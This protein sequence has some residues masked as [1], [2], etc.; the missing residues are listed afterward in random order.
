MATQ[1]SK[2]KVVELKDLLKERGIPTTGLTR[3]QSIIDALE[4]RDSEVSGGAVAV[5]A[6]EDGKDG[7]VE[8]VAAEEKSDEGHGVRSD[9][10]ET[11]VEAQKVEADATEVKEAPALEPATED[12]GLDV[13]PDATS[14]PASTAT[15]QQPTVL[16]A[17]EPVSSKP[18]SELATPQQHSG[19]LEDASPESRKRK[20]R[21]PTP[22]LSDE[23]VSKK[24]KAAEEAAADPVKLTDDA[25]IEDA[26]VSV[27]GAGEM[28]TE[29]A[30][31]TVQ[32]YSTSDDLQDVNTED[33]TMTDQPA[34]PDAS[35]AQD[36]PAGAIHP[37]TRALYIR[38][39]I[40]PLQPA[41]LRD[42]LIALAGPDS[43]D[44]LIEHFHL[45]VLR[46]HAFAVFST[47]KAATRVRAALHGTVF[48]DEPARKSL[49]V[50]FVPEEKVAEWIEVEASAGTS[51]RDAR[52]WEVLYEGS[53]EGTAVQHVE[54]GGA[55]R[56]GSIRQGSMTQA[57]STGTGA[58]GGMPNAPLGP[59][60]NGTMIQRPS[61]PQPL[62]TSIAAE[63]QEA[64]TGDDESAVSVTANPATGPS[65]SSFTTLAKTFLC[66]TT[67]PHLYYLPKPDE[68]ATSRLQALERETSRDW[69]GARAG[70]GV[71]EGYGGGLRRYTFEDG[72]RLVDG[73]A[74]RG[75]FG[76]FG[77]DGYGRGAFRGR[78]RGGYRGYGGYGGGGGG[79]RG[80]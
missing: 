69:T 32:P 29:D 42:H 24:L 62:A 35:F 65:A 70:D 61:Q 33:A 19:T 38:D 31:K 76:T 16:E 28:D 67:K 54:V 5:D 23:T 3:K 8:V 77:G 22:S 15:P 10:V 68:L 55:G 59:R 6:P 79:Y 9:K 72:D 17:G 37:A 47:L 21:S 71:G 1:Y 75:S 44:S 53:G 78:G 34:N 36:S 66:T 30:G 13:L 57:A 50:D 73:G 27:R 26:P 41:Q 39:L 56:E 58:G 48:P 63:P 45:D 80:R 43:T 25:V 40:R 20:R 12:Q 4:K 52:K 60:G 11:G 14:D 46:T 64:Q 7:E 51:R 18:T 49:W 74:D 2:L